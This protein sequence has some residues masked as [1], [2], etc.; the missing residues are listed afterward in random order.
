[1]IFTIAISGLIVIE[2][3]GQVSSYYHN[4]LIKQDKCDKCF[5]A[6]YANGFDDGGIEA[7]SHLKDQD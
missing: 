3:V 1:M 7:M 2:I 6:G 4:K 5:E